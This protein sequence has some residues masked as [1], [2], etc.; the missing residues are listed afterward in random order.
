MVKLYIAFFSNECMMQHTPFIWDRL[1]NIRIHMVIS[2]NFILTKED[3]QC[4]Q[5]S[6]ANHNWCPVSV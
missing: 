4:V 5:C 6:H 3:W 2:L 1:E